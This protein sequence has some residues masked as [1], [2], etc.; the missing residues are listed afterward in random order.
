MLDQVSAMFS[1]H[2]KL[3]LLRFDLHQPEA[4]PTSKHLTEFLK[5]SLS[6]V[7]RKYKLSRAIY[8]WAREAESTDNQHYHCFIA[9]DGNKVQAPHAITKLFAYDWGL[10]YD[11][12]LHWPSKRCYYQI[13]RGNRELLQEAIFHI[14]YLA[15]SRGKGNKP[16]QAKD[17]GMSRLKPKMESDD[18]E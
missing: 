10:Y 14:S 9:L 2:N 1:Y 7:I 16:N 6:K 12:H 8:A 18:L 4:T 15:K 17:Y 11:G 5:S 13:K 3:F